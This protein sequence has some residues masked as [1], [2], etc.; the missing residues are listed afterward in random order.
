MKRLT[1]KELIH[2][3]GQDIWDYLFEDVKLP[4][5]YQD[6]ELGDVDLSSFYSWL[7]S[8][9]IGDEEYEDVEWCDAFIVTSHGRVA[10][11]KIDNQ[12]WKGVTLQSAK[13]FATLGSILTHEGVNKNIAIN[14]EVEKIWGI[15]LNYYDLPKE[16]QSQ[17][18]VSKNAK[19]DMGIL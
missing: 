13:P 3:S 2:N 14:K 19:R 1:N 15:K 12:C 9:L 10:R 11:K 8:E 4:R 5:V 18:K 17:V 7:D 6:P 16:V